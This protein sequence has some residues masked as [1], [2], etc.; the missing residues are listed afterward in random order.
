MERAAFCAFLAVASG[1]RMEI[2]FTKM[3]GCGNDYVYIDGFEYD[4]ENP[5][6]LAVKMADR[7]FGVGGDGIIMICPSDVADAKMRMFNLDGSEGKM[8][9]NGIRCV[10]RYLY[11]RR[12]I[13]KDELKIET[14]SGIKTIHINLKDGEFESATVNMG[15]AEFES[16]K[17]PVVSDKAEVID[18][19]LTVGG[20]D[21]K[22]TCVSMGNP[23]CV[24][25]CDDPE[26]IELE[27]IGSLFE[28]NKIFPEGVNTEFVRI[29]DAHTIEMRVW[30]R[31]SGETLA[32]GT[33]SCAAVAASKVCGKVSAEGDVTVKLRGGELRV[34]YN[35]DRVLMTGEA[36]FVFDGVSTVF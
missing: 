11:D 3:Y 25:F 31:G 18:E 19:P 30:E 27:K 20:R 26:K 29:I 28:K 35:S 13:H 17:I 5:S 16:S 12:K 9:G 6:E 33:G 32:C 34:N 8:C 21:Y 7:H 4:I 10:S 1:E 36:V 14:L 2:K 24:V 23:H 22:I 15:K